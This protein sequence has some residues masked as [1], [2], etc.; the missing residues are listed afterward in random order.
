V[1]TSLWRIL[2]LLASVRCVCGQTAYDQAAAYLRGGDATHAI[3]MLQEIVASAPRDLKAQNLLGIALLTAG[4]KEEAGSHF[5]KALEVDPNFLPA[6]KNLAVCEAALGRQQESKAHFEK[7]LAAAP[8]D[9]VAHL[10]LADFAFNAQDYASASRHYRSSAELY[11]Q[12]T[13]ST[14]RFARA[15]L[16]TG[17]AAGAEGALNHLP[18]DAAE[19]Q[20]QSGVMLAQAK[21]YRSAAGHFEIAA[22][23]YPDRYQAGFNLALVYLKSG[24][25]VASIR[26]AEAIAADFPKAELQNLLSQAYEGAGRTQQAYDALRVAIRLE[27]AD[28]R[29]YLDLMALCLAHENWDLSLEISDIAL[30][31]VPASY[32]LRMQ[33][34]AVLAMKGRL[35]QA[36]TEF[37]AAEKLAPD[38]GLP[39]VA[40]AIV[41]LE[42]KEPERA[43]TV[44]RRRREQHGGD[45]RVDWLLGEALMQQGSDEQAVPLLTEAVRL[46]PEA[47]QPRILLGKLLEKH[48]QTSESTRCFEEAHRLDPQDRSAAYHLAVLYRKAGKVTEAEALLRQVGDA[49]SA[50]EPLPTG[51]REL[52]RILRTE[53]RP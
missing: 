23:T 47:V 6:L 19:S 35:D 4:R 8:S 49:T 42:K 3:P 40:V 39:S 45:Y 17:D 5:L 37:R 15:A 10:Y 28:E 9:P 27:P 21:R 34:G 43:I 14:L 13:D 26:A 36:E 1:K 38:T 20:F 46:N 2:F 12:N 16:E 44:L 32:R 22:R 53:P 33:R 24:D 31:R 50:S 51:S 41:A 52:V 29:N 7:L 30:Q 11:L 18:A 25:S 48:G